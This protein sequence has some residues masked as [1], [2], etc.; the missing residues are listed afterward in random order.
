MKLLDD[1]VGASTAPE[2]L[3]VLPEAPR[4][5]AA[6]WF[7]A[8]LIFAVGCFLRI[9]PWLGFKG[10]G[11]DE[12]LYRNYVEALADK[13]FGNMPNLSAAYL[14]KQSKMD[15]AILPPT[16]FLYIAAATTWRNAFFADV[17][18]EPD[19]RADGVATRDPA[20]I[21]LRSVSCLFTILTLIVGAVF[22]RRLSGDRAM[23]G[24]LALLACAPTQLHMAQHGLIDG[25]FAFWALTCAWLLWENLHR[26]DHGRW[27]AAYAAA[28]ALMVLT[29]ENAAFVYFALTGMLLVA[30]WQN[31]GRLT[32]RLALTHVA[33]A[34]LG[35]VLLVALAGGVQECLAMYL[36]LKAKAQMM[37]YAI[38]TGDGPW[39][40]YLVD[41]LCAS[42]LTLL[43]AIGAL[44]NLTRNNKPHL[45]LTA[46]IA[47]SYLMMCN[48]KYGMN[49]RYT[50]M[51]DMPLRFLAFSQLGLLAKHFGKREHW[52]LLGGIVVLC[53]LDLRQYDILFV[54]FN[55]DYEMISAN[56][57]QALRILKFH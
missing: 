11:F 38:R 4:T 24:V 29:K 26:P 18:A 54:Q 2:P 35:G 23:L 39:F 27:Q 43:L 47:F 16:R 30:R 53:A 37:P 57:L 48:V 31:W 34:L 46:F 1:N 17:P 14:Q 50:N 52:V 20:L 55:V 28:L 32:R 8:L 49:L 51:W 13:G 3:D 15:G 41:L 25:V 10:I 22:A 44:F 36:L 5:T 7:A 19:L 21:S 12:A 56:L 40:R 6:I 33:G 42:P 45:Y 9:H